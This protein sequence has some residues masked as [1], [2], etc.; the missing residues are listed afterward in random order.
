M[1]YLREK[2]CGLLFWRLKTGTVSGDRGQWVEKER[3]TEKKVKEKNGVEKEE[4]D[5]DTRGV[6]LP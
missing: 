1:Q 4:R 5:T 6:M 2:R 3:P